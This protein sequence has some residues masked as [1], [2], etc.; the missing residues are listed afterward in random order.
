MDPGSADSSAVKVDKQE[1]QYS[2]TEYF[3]GRDSI[4]KRIAE[5]LNDPETKVMLVHGMAGIGK[6]EICRAVYRQLKA[7]NPDFSMPFIDITGT[8]QH[9]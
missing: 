8:K 5:K 2:R 1:I 3:I 4:V 9:G 6:T 7:D